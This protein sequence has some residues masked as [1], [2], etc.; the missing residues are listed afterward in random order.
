MAFNGI[1]RRANVTDLQTTMVGV[2]KAMETDRSMNGDVYPSTVP[3]RVKP[4]SGVQ[5]S[6]V[7]GDANNYCIEGVSRSDSNLKMF[8]SNTSKDP[9][10]GSC[11]TGEDTSYNPYTSPRGESIGGSSTSGWSLV[12]GGSELSCG[13]YNSVPYC[14]GSGGL[15][16]ST[17]HSIIP[18]P[19]DMNGVLSGKTIKSMSIST[20]WSVG[21]C[22]IASDNN[23]YCWGGNYRGQL[24][25]GE[26]MDSN[27]PVAVY[28][29]GVLSDKTIKQISFG[30]ATTCAVASDNNAYCWGY[31]GTIGMLGSGSVLDSNIPVAVNTD[32]DLS[33]KTVKE[34][35][36]GGTH[37][38]LIA[39]DN[40]A[41]C[42]GEGT[43][44]RLGNG[45]TGTYTTPKAVYTGGVLSGKNLVSISIGAR[46]TCAVASDGKAYCWGWNT[47]GQLG[48][49]LNTDS[50]V[51]VEVKADGVLSGKNL[52]KIVAGT[53][54][55][56]AL[57]SAGAVYCW[58]VNE[59]STYGSVP[60]AVSVAGKTV[61][62]ISSRGNHVCA[63]A[64]DGTGYCW[65]ANNQGELGLG[66]DTYTSRVDPT[67]I[68]NP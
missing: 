27:L 35:S 4:S 31:S 44:G 17:R 33:S 43:N 26:N 57:D 63:T 28:R 10:Y 15:G 29:G 22:V 41:Y 48:N 58:G 14:W 23:A 40:N 62:D 60:V 20:R 61:K 24:G 6:Y 16:S 13:V 49:G 11:V 8:V 32:G 52:K 21:A 46:H 37:A 51:P 5:L 59:T 7:S 12:E 18:V 68:I 47:D 30:D 64:D 39:S 9:K 65:G 2:S 54:Q 66:D 56:C 1:T 38:C 53:W 55:T 34:V 42:W 25:N 45:E 19:V 67:Q 50:L 3:T 36:V